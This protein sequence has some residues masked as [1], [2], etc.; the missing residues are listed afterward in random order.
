MRKR[1]DTRTLQRQ[2]K[3]TRLNERL[4]QQAVERERLRSGRLSAELQQYKVETAAYRQVLS[5]LCRVITLA[6]SAAE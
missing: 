6:L 1:T 5:H 2:L 3:Q 4:E